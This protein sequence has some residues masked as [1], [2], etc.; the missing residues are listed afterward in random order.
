MKIVLTFLALS[1][2]GAKESL[3][4]NESIK[5]MGSS[6]TLERIPVQMLGGGIY[7][8]HQCVMDIA[9]GGGILNVEGLPDEVEYVSAKSKFYSGDAYFNSTTLIVPEGVDYDIEDPVLEPEQ[10][11]GSA[12]V[13]NSVLV[14]RGESTADGGGVVGVTLAELSDSVFGT[15]GDPINLRTQY[16]ACSYEKIEFKPGPPM[17]G[18]DAV[19]G[20]VTVTTPSSF[21]G[22]SNYVGESYLRAALQTMMGRSL[23]GDY[24]QIMFCIPPGTSA[25]WIAYA[26]VNGWRSVYNNLWCTYVSSQMHEIGHNIGLAHSGITGSSEYADQSDMMGYSYSQDD[27]PVMCFNAPKNYQ[28]GWYT[29]KQISLSSSMMPWQGFLMGIATYESAIAGTHYVLLRIPGTSKDFYV[30]YNRKIGINSGSVKFGNKV[31]V[32]ERSTG[33]GYA[34]SWSLADLGAGGTYTLEGTAISVQVLSISGDVAEVKIVA[35]SPTNSPVRKPSDS[36]VKGPSTSPVKQPTTGPVVNPNKYGWRIWFKQSDTSRSDGVSDVHELDFHESND[37]SD[38][39]IKPEGDFI[40]SG[41]YPRESLY[42]KSA[43]DDNYK[44]MWGGRSV[45][46]VFWLGIMYPKNHTVSCINLHQLNTNIATRIYIQNMVEGVWTTVHTAQGLVEGKN[47]IRWNIGPTS[48]PSKSPASMPSD[49]PV[50]KPTVSPVKK[51]TVSPVK[52]PTVS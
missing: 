25:G 52:K 21:S 43:F 49:S 4:S 39:E 16:M 34:L 15:A 2:F 46:G 33:S 48:K 38:A 32:H 31:M 24:D 27:S 11:I 42:P 7:E 23:P 6:C 40:A 51:P 19:N 26:S 44:S 29:D 36:P 8:D 3:A 50:K 18:V 20:A 22:V 41:S 28:L 17:D 37:C 12:R 10:N 47:T 13:T 5:R 1:C 14:V 45:S 35:G 9:D 30:S